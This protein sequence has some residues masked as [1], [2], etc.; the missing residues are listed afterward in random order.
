M[1]HGVDDGSRFEAAMHHAIGAFLVIADAVSVPVGLFHQL[2][3]GLGIALA[4][5]IAGPLPAEDGARGIAPGRAMIGLIAG[6]EIE[7]QQ[8]L[9]ERPVVAAL[10]RRENIAEQLLG[11]CS[12]LS[13]CC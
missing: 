5:Q 13:K 7:E 11:L 9:K 8:R 3:E 10:P 6:Q 2:L 4:E 12:R 1:V